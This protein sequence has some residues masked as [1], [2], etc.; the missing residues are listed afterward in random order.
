MKPRKLVES[1]RFRWARA[2]TAWRAA[3]LR[4]RGVPIRAPRVIGRSVAL[5]W[6]DTPERRGTLEFGE[7]ITLERGVVINTSGGDVAVGRDVH[8][9]PYSVIYAHG[10]VE[11]GDDTL[12]AMHCCI[13]A[14]NHNVPPIGITIRSQPDVPARVRIGR[15][16]WLGARVCVLAGV[17]I[18]DGCVVGAGSV[19]TTSIPPG[20]IAHGTPARVVAFRAGAGPARE[21]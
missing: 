15:D 2:M 3:R 19:V 18:G 8:I 16:V 17:E 6:H 13:A 1:L 11:I 9:G 20:A 12:I 4:I 10:G 14:A 5:R 7:N 21:K